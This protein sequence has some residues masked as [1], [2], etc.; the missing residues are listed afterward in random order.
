MAVRNF[1]AILMLRG[2][3]TPNTAPDLST[4]LIKSLYFPRSVIITQA[5]VM[6]N[7][8][9]T[10]TAILAWKTSKIKYRLILRI[11]LITDGVYT[12]KRPLLQTVLVHSRFPNLEYLQSPLQGA[13]GGSSSIFLIR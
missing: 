12:Y 6:S 8:D 10:Y 4:D 11:Q 2:L 3:L 7:K 9:S 13:I 1:I 5:F